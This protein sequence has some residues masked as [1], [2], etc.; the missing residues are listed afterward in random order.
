VSIGLGIFASV[1][2][3]LA[4]Y[5]PGFRK[6]LLWT[7]G[8]AL[9]VAVIGL[10]GYFAYDRYETWST[11]REIARDNAKDEAAKH[12]AILHCMFRLGTPMTDSRQPTLPAQYS[13]NLQAC[14]AAPDDWNPYSAFGGNF[15]S[16]SVPLPAGYKLDESHHVVP[17]ALVC[18][19]NLPFGFAM[20]S[21]CLLSGRVVTGFQ[22]D[23]CIGTIQLNGD[24]VIEV[25][26]DQRK[27][28]QGQYMVQSC[29][30]D[31]PLDAATNACPPWKDVDVKDAAARRAEYLKQKR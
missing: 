24:C 4:V 29:P 19:D 3:I 5:H 20:D 9:S 31:L 23:M 16:D 17:N 13:A 18:P 21:S 6:V 11:E 7:A 2:L 26:A 1:V 14:T 15:I 25:P 30:F 27:N 28:Y 8:V 10:L 22:R 12:T